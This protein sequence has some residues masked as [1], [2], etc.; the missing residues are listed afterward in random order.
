MPSFYRADESAATRAATGFAAHKKRRP[1]C[2]GIAATRAPRMIKT[3]ARTPH[4]RRTSSVRSVTR[5]GRGGKSAL[6]VGVRAAGHRAPRVTVANTHRHHDCIL[7]LFPHLRGVK[8]RLEMLDTVGGGAEVCGCDRWS[9]RVDV[10]GGV[11]EQRWQILVSHAAT[12]A[13][14]PAAVLFFS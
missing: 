12:L 13:C 9:A 14:S 1:R 7:C 6:A 2:S 3:P 8:H 5:R 4:P 10:L 11:T